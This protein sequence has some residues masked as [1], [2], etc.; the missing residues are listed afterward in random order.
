MLT[1]IIN[2]CSRN[3][4]ALLEEKEIRINMVYLQWQVAY[5]YSQMYATSM[6]KS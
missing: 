4:T 5:A 1:Q 2:R 6:A 3:K